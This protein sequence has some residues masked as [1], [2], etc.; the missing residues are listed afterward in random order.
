MSYSR[1]GSSDWYTMWMAPPVDTENRDNA[2]FEIMCVA[3]FTAK[4][5]R[6]NIDD[7]MKKVQ[8]IAPEGDILELRGYVSEFL[9]DVDKEYPPYKNI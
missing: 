6:E 5:L 1:W 8:I 9:A 2:I 3:R 7:C 4:E